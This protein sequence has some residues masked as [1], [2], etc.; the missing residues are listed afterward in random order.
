MPKIMIVLLDH[1]SVYF[2]GQ[3]VRGHMILDL[4][5]YTDVQCKHSLIVLFNSRLA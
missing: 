5:D 2:P 3:I 1:Q 4:N